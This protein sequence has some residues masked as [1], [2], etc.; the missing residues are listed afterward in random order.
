M[1]LNASMHSPASGAPKPPLKSALRQS[2]VAVAPKTITFAPKM[3]T[4]AQ[5][6]QPLQLLKKPPPDIKRKFS[7]RVDGFF[8]VKEMKTMVPSTISA[9]REWFDELVAIDPSTLIYP[10]SNSSRDSPL[11]KSADFPSSLLKL[12]VYFNKIAAPK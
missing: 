2:G 1:K 12:S 4:F 5:T 3:I 7:I 6:I 11:T 8:K 10:W 9:V